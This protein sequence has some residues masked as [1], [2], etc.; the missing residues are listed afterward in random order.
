LQPPLL[1]LWF[2]LGQA[3]GQ[4]VAPQLRPFAG[5]LRFAGP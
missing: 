1:V 3:Y 4:S 5:Q 2:G